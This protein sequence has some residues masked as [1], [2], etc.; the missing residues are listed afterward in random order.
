MGTF[1]QPT[2]P[3]C[4]SRKVF[5]MRTFG[6]AGLRKEWSATYGFD[7]YERFPHLGPTLSKHKC[8][9]CDLGFFL[10]DCVGDAAFYA[11]LSRGR[12]WYYEANKWAF[13][14]AVRRLNASPQ[15]N[16]LLEIGCGAGFFLEKVA[17]CYDTLGIDINEDAVRICREKN[18]NVVAARLETIGRQF[19]AVVA[20]D[21]LEH[22][23]DPKA[24]LQHVYEALTPGGAVIFSVPNPDGYLE[25]FD[26]LLLDMPPHHAT[27]W[28]KS[29]LEYAA[30]QF[31]LQIIEIA[32]E[33]LSYAHYRAYVKMLLSQNPSFA[34][35]SLS[36]RLNRKIRNTLAS[37]LRDLFVPL[38]YQYHK[39]TLAGHTH[40]VEYRK[41]A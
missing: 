17:G 14:E 31:G 18:L 34:G 36:Q 13:D 1:A 41:V 26:H 16:T 21:L 39:Q 2:C 3:L 4:G 32:N 10:P 33:P 30:R 9:A 12:D 38:N 20:F 35:R 19:D 29:A 28:S 27:Q 11:Q 25:E 23:P 37:I 40:L 8:G 24:F 6:V 22:I 15:I 5:K 7:P